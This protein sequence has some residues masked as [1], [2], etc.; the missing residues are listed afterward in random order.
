MDFEKVMLG[1]SRKLSQGQ[2][3]M[4]NMT[5]DGFLSV[6]QHCQENLLRAVELIC[7]RVH[8]IRV[9]RG[10][11]LMKQGD[12]GKAGSVCLASEGAFTGWTSCAV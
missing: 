11:T 7:N 6:G 9:P 8:N 5:F 10:E 3:K 1:A 2:T 4:E 12:P